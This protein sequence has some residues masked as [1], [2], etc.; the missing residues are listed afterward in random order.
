MAG[1]AARHPTVVGR[2]NRGPK[3]A[4]G[5]GHEPPS[6]SRTKGATNEAASGDDRP[7]W[8]RSKPSRLALRARPRLPTED[9]RGQKPRADDPAGAAQVAVRVNR[10]NPAM[11][12]RLRRI[13]RKPKPVHAIRFQ[14][15]AGVGKGSIPASGQ[16]DELI[17]GIERGDGADERV[18][19]G[20]DR[21]RPGW[22]ARRQLHHAPAPGW[23]GFRRPP[24]PDPVAAQV[25]LLVT[26]THGHQRT[27]PAGKNILAL[28]NSWLWNLERDIGRRRRPRLPPGSWPSGRRLRKS[29]GET[30]GG[31]RRVQAEGWPGIGLCRRSAPRC[32]RQSRRTRANGVIQRDAKA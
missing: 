15:F 23:E 4:S 13:E 6:G 21:S 9:L 32:H 24:L 8:S 31:D 26:N 29:E 20:R 12:L 16:L 10:G 3:T 5:D 30:G 25:V 18:L 19:S 11:R 22:I 14:D 2:S 27:L 28:S 17:E 1:D 7:G